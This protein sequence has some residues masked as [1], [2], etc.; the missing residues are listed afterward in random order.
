MNVK[1]D[2]ITLNHSIYS[3]DANGR[4]LA[5]VT[6]PEKEPGVFCIDGTYVCE[7]LLA[8]GVEEDLMD[9]AVQKIREQHGKITATAPYA[10]KYLHERHLIQGN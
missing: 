8:H 4:I 6:F 9:R 10:K 3:K 1:L 5:E 7:D 2:Y